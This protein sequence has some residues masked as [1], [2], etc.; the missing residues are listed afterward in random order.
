MVED[1]HNAGFWQF[2]IY[3]LGKKAQ[4]RFYREIH[5]CKFMLLS[6]LKRYL[7]LLPNLMTQKWEQFSHP[8]KYSFAKLQYLHL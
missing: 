4:R 1:M 8:E 6:A 5:K 2:P 7:L 3:C